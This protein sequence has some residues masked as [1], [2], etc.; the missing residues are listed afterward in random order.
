MPFITQHFGI[1]ITFA[2][3]ITL[4]YYAAAVIFSPLMGRIG[5]QVGRKE[6]LI[7]GL[8]IFTTSEF[9]AAM[10]PTYII[11][12]FARFIQGIGY[13]CVF[14]TVFAF[15]SELF[16]DTKSGK[17]VALLGIAGSIGAASG[18]VIAG[19]LIA[20][21]NWTIIYWI[22]GSFSS[23][24]LLIVLAVMPKTIVRRKQKIDYKGAGA[25]L[26]TICSLVSIPILVS[27]FGM[28]SPITL[29]VI[30][31]GIVGLILLIVVER[32]AVNPVMDIKILRLR[33]IHVPAMIAILLTFGGIALNYALAFYIASRAGW[34]PTEV[35]L[36][37][38]LNYSFTIIGSFL[39]G[40]LIDR[41]NPKYVIL[42]SSVVSLIGAI[43]FTYISSQ[44]P[45][46]YLIFTMA[47]IGFSSGLINPGL[48]KI[49]ILSVPT[50]AKGVGSGT[51]TMFR[52]LGIP[53]GSTFG[54]AVFGFMSQRQAKLVA[55]PTIATANAL[56]SVGYVVIGI[57]V[58]LML[59]SL[60]L[61]R[62]EKK[63]YN[64]IDIVN[65]SVQAK[66]TEE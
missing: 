49:V 19:Y 65:S 48:M 9:L 53:L 22:S 20:S 33:G 7:I 13:A 50:S 3:S 1:P 61:F 44:S 32:T 57:I 23:M 66:A 43:M 29:S 51:F 36:I 54:L 38:T 45:F 42:S 59:I 37:S 27:N 64:A 40:S 25:L 39:A 34:G 24:G 56:N 62:K 21:F 35:G 14:P 55:D 4:A 41:Y 11:F 10:S 17:A 63:A 8:V 28:S 2:G 52:D 60:L 12:L 26:I 30:A 6:I 31:I 47:L 18:G 46:M 16:D 58:L 15:I 5:D